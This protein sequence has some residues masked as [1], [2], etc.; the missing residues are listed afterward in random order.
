MKKKR[1]PTCMEIEM[2]VSR[3]WGWRTNVIVP[4]ISWG[5][6]VHECDLLILSKAG[7]ATEIEIKVSRSDL[8][9][10]AE[11]KHAHSSDKIKYLYFAIPN[12]LL[13]CLEFIPERA[14][15]II[16][17]AYENEKYEGYHGEVFRHPEV[18]TSAKKWTEVERVNLGRLGCMRIWSLKQALIGQINDKRYLQKEMQ[19]S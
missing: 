14:G 10:D 17:T 11:K 19:K 5:A 13:N 1:V 15:V 16:I 4:N 7:W 9:K 8:K 3:L 6:G 12:T 2:I 18:N